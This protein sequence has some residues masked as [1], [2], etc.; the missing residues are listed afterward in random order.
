MSDSTVLTGNIVDVVA[1]SIFPGRV[2]LAGGRIANVEE[3]PGESYD[4]LI[5]PGLIDA[6]VHVESSL[7]SPSE[8]GRAALIHG[9]VASVSDPHEIA[10]VLGIKGVEWML[11]DARNTPFDISFG[12]PS[13][14][15][16]TPF[17]TAG[18]TFGP[19]EVDQLLAR[20][21]IS[22]LA[23]VMNFPG[24]INRD[25]L[26]M[27]IIEKAKARGKRIDGHAP[28]VTGEHIKKYVAAGIETDHE[29]ITLD[30]ARAKCQLGMKIAIREGSAA[31]NFDA[32]WPLL[33]EFPELCFFCSDDKHPDDLIVSHINALVARAISLGIDPMVAF[34][35]AIL[36][37]VRHYGLKVGLLQSGDPADVA[38]FDSLESMQCLRC[39]K[40]GQLVAENGESKLDYR[41]VEPINLF[42]AKQ[43]RPEDFILP[44]ID[45]PRRVIVALDGQ[46]ITG[47]ETLEADGPDTAHDL[48]LI[49]VVNRYSET[50]PSVAL[51]KG[52]GLKDGAMA[53]SVAHDSHN[54]VVVGTNVRDLSRAV[55]LVI[56]A[57]GGLSVIA[58]SGG[59][60]LPLPIAGLMSDGTCADVADSFTA[61]TNA[62]KSLGCQLA[63]PYMT[64][65]FM[66]LLVIPK[67]KISDK[68][69][70][71]V[72][73]FSLL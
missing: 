4:N 27:A 45:G 38:E 19:E 68:G 59:R 48:C 66:A 44:K 14:V 50:P 29:S 36:N 54:V 47:E 33:K 65:S 12:A 15:P 64:L 17:E 51:I 55:N 22:H 23:E 9:T 6:H 28:A 31:R 43:K 35:V 56:A 41:R 26:M 40:D 2:T 7:L 34:R 67:L 61:L 5:C 58:G 24:V 72:E 3:T 53:S 73:T 69:L 71:D 13:C 42:E 1:G 8:F 63:S 21:E 39:W 16:A 52:F 62:A 25:P 70:F 30:E 46:I 57:G 37:P 32:I 60:I 20:D 49:S 18:A 10:N 11:E